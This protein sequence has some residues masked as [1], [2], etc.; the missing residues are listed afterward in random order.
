MS[1]GILNNLSSVHTEIIKSV[2]TGNHI[3]SVQD[4]S[5]TKK[6]GKILSSSTGSGYLEP[7]YGMSQQERQW[8]TNP[9]NKELVAVIYESRNL[10][11]FKGMPETHLQWLSDNRDAA[12]C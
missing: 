11:A 5:S 7:F 4:S 10:D 6:D 2:K 12:T 8:I 3:N 1:I 9:D